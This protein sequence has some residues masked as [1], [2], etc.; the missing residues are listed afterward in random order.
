[1]FFFQNNNKERMKYTI[2]ENLL[3]KK[4]AGEIIKWTKDKSAIKCGL[5]SFGSS[6]Q[7][8]DKTSIKTYPVRKEDLTPAMRRISK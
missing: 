3:T 6:S 1:M 5:I 7:T 4:E 8:S 2:F